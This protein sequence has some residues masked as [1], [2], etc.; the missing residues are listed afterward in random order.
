VAALE[1][2]VKLE[3]ML[4]ANAERLSQMLFAEQEAVTGEP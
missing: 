3:K 4:R 2:E 1:E